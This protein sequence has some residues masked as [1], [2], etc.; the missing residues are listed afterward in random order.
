MS[1]VND[2]PSEADDDR[3]EG[4]AQP[5]P[6]SGPADRRNL[7]DIIVRIIGGRTGIFSF[8]ILAL[9]AIALGTIMVTWMEFDPAM[10]FGRLIALAGAVL[11]L[12]Y[13]EKSADVAIRS[14]G[15]LFIAALIVTPDD[16][17]RVWMAFNDDEYVFD[18]SQ[19]E[20]GVVRSL[21]SDHELLANYT[22]EELQSYE[23]FSSEFSIYEQDSDLVAARFS[24]ELMRCALQEATMAVVLERIRYDES[25]HLLVE[26]NS[27]DDEPWRYS[28]LVS[29]DDADV[30]EIQQ[31]LELLRAL[32]LVAF[33]SDSYA[34]AEV[35]ARG[36]RALADAENPLFSRPSDALRSLM[37]NRDSQGAEIEAKDIETA[38][39]GSGAC[40]SVKRAFENEVA[41]NRAQA[42]SSPDE[43]PMPAEIAAYSMDRFG[44]SPLFLPEDEDRLFEA[45]FRGA[46]AT[47]AEMRGLSIN[48]TTRWIL[49]DR[50]ELDEARPRLAVYEIV[51]RSTG[52]DQPSDPVIRVVDEFDNI[53][54]ENDDA[55]TSDLVS[56]A[57]ESPYLSSHL[58]I[59]LP[60]D[61]DMFWIGIQSYS[62]SRA[63]IVDLEVY[64]V[65]PDRLDG[66]P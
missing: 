61:V 20:Y 57:P 24:D 3:R 46:G 19:F 21:T 45:S 4:G 5:D 28:N 10:V 59:V 31:Q 54:G 35:T 37:L 25:F 14:L 66:E 56:G 36:A 27:L 9:T 63:G 16:V 30:R 13:I 29:R 12:I 60:G 52:E 55:P 50:S 1:D 49:I 62:P 32:D 11:I 41:R 7:A 34:E 47:V 17:I 65:P 64:R 8:G 2:G 26:M 18:E 38:F 58:T 42:E 44:P 40:A 6:V 53:L 22:L 23:A 51:A 33:R 48:T 39:N 15:L 43:R